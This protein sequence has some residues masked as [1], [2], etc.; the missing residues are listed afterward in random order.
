MKASKFVVSTIAAV[1]G[2]IGFASA[3]SPNT[4]T[5]RPV[6]AQSPNPAT[7]SSTTPAD[8]QTQF[9]RT[10]DSTRSPRERATGSNRPSDMST[11]AGT[12][13]GADTRTMSAERPA[14]A[15]R[16]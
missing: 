12:S 3:Q 13:A 8:T 15:D 2:A 16:N 5:D 11:G 4:P 1:F 10:G 9:P 7:P 14:R 6:G